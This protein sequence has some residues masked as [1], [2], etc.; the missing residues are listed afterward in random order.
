MPSGMGA[1]HAFTAAQLL[2]VLTCAVLCWLQM[3]QQTQHWCPNPERIFVKSDG[4]AATADE[5]DAAAARMQSN[6]EQTAT[7]AHA[8]AGCC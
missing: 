3:L 4:S 6:A 2:T 1:S 8:G 7:A 5:L